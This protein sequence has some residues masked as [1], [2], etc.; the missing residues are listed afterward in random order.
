MARLPTIAAYMDQT[1]HTV[2]EDM[3]IHEAVAF[4]LDNHVTGAPVLGAGGRLIGIITEYDL[5]R[6]LSIGDDHQPV[7]GR[8]RDYMTRGVITVPPSM[9]IYFAAGIFMGNRFRRLP[10]VDDGKLVG[11]IT[12]FDILRAIRDHRGEEG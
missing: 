7:D 9:N 8:V 12:R 3:P 6:L 5:L 2:H 1:V 10:V 11:G 4:L